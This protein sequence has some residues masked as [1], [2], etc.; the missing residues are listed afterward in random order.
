VVRDMMTPGGFLH[1][2]GLSN[3]SGVMINTLSRRCY[4]SKTAWLVPRIARAVPFV[5]F[6]LVSGTKS[7]A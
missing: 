4:L 6:I 1:D 2:E 5:G 7:V 3:A